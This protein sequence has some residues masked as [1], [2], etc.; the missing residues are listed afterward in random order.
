MSDPPEQSSSRDEHETMSSHALTGQRSPVVLITTPANGIG[1]RITRDPPEPSSLP[2]EHETMSSQPPDESPATTDTAPTASKSDPSL[3]DPPEPSSSVREHGATISNAPDNSQPS[4]ATTDT[5]PAVSIEAFSTSA[6]PDQSNPLYEHVTTN[7]QSPTKP[8][9]PFTG[10]TRNM[11]ETAESG[12]QLSEE[13]VWIL[14]DSSRVQ[15]ALP[16]SPSSASRVLKLPPSPSSSVSVSRFVELPPPPKPSFVF[17]IMK[18]PPELRL[19]VFDQLFLDLTV[20]RQ[21]FMMYHNEEKLL[22]KHQVND[23]RPYTN[24]LLTCKELSDEA[25]KL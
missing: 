22:H 4:P 25:K 20:R 15:A 18:L 2:R 11:P 1:E 24:M 9:L 6:P 12:I 10:T 14:K 23:F 5:S 8:Q 7:S 3:S 19:M 17:P 16:L 13:P 21:R